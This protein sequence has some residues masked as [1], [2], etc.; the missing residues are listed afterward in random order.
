MTPVTIPSN[1]VYCWVTNLNNTLVKECLS[2]YRMMIKLT[3]CKTVQKKVRENSRYIKGW[4]S[5]HKYAPTSEAGRKKLEFYRC[6][7]INAA[8]SVVSD[9]EKCHPVLTTTF[10][11]FL[12]ILKWRSKS[13]LL[14]D[15]LAMKNIA[16]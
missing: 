8:Q 13:I 4:P 14:D 10:V 7:Y 16:L 11:M 5:L 1:S 6:N 2:I 15:M 9:T 12:P 3:L